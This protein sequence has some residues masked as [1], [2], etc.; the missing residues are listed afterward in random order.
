[1]RWPI[2]ATIQRSRKSGGNAR[3]LGRSE[4]AVKVTVTNIR[5]YRQDG[6]SCQAYISQDRIDVSSMDGHDS[7]SGLKT[8]RLGDG[9]PLNYIDENTFKNVITGE[10]L[11]SEE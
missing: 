1:M 8:I 6:S 2:S 5:L 7:I 3:S 11:R 10:L 4:K 9:T